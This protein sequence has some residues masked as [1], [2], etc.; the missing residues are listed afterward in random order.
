[1]KTRVMGIV[2][3]T[4]DSFSDGGE[5]F[6][7]EEAVAHGK[8]LASEGADVL[9]VG[10]EST[11]PGAAPVPVDEEMR[12][13]VPVVRALASV[14]QVSVDTRHAVVAEAALAA[15]ATMVNDVSA[16]SD[17]AMASVVAA[18]KA[19]C[20]L[21]HMQGDP[22]TMQ[23]A[24]TYRDVVGEV[25]AHLEARAR[26]A[27]AAGVRGDRILVD[28]GL[29]FGKTFEHNVELLRSLPRLARLGWP[30]VVGSSRKS[31]V[32]RLLDDGTGAPGPRARLEGDLALAVHAAT[33]GAAMVRVHDVGATVRALRVADRVSGR[34]PLWTK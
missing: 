10:G 1:M 32:G 11:R 18:R 24:P 28:P 33:C 4:P 31:F 14:A 17:P 30:L 15:G 5:H 3:A 25:A 22:A 34:M 20:V 29:G 13:V 23:D 21:M 6:R 26:A 9:D 7:T 8:R 2:N 16:L 12:R 19:E 27:E